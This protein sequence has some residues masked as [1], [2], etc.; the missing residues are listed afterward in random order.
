MKLIFKLV[1]IL[2]VFSAITSAQTPAQTVPDFTFY[3]FNGSSFTNKHL[4]KGKF[5]FFIFFDTEC[6]HCQHAIKYLNDHNI[7][8]N[9][10]AMYLLTLDDKEKVKQFMNTYGKNLQNKTNI[11]FLQDVKNEF[12][13]KFKPEKYPSIFLYSASKK[14]LL[15]DDNEQNLFMFLAK[16]KTW[17]P[18]SN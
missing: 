15:Y 1:T 18:S 12:I 3:K 17:S 9:K 6:E 4:D 8:L 10:T 11:T 13:I 7:E 5:L 2:L 14:L 16:I